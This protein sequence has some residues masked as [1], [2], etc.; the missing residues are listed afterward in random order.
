MNRLRTYFIA[1]DKHR[2]SQADMTW[3]PDP[4]VPL[5]KL[6]YEDERT[7][8]CGIASAGYYRKDGQAQIT[9]DCHCGVT[10]TATHEDSDTAQ[11]QAF[12]LLVAHARS[13]VVA[14]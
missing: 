1:H 8:L 9:L 12:D 2:P 11:D 3:Q 13:M 6:A 14:A 10:V 7:D 5:W 4:T